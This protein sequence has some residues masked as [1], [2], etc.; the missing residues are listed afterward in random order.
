MS[1]LSPYSP[2]LSIQ[3]RPSLA[4]SSTTLFI[5]RWCP[6]WTA[7]N[8]APKIGLTSCLPPWTQCGKRWAL[9][10]R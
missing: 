8:A 2:I 6:P 5:T 10:K 7:S 9:S 3:P 1:K 4:G